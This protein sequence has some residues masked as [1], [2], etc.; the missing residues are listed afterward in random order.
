[1][2]RLVV[3]ETTLYG[4]SRLHVDD[5]YGGRIGWVDLNTGVVVLERR[6]LRSAF[7]AAVAEWKSTHDRIERRAVARDLVGATA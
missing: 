5:P 6:D 4:R 3:T 2:T 1:M 7:H